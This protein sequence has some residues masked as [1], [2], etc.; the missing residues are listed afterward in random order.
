MN[1]SEFCRVD[2]SQN[3]IS[4]EGAKLLTEALRI[5]PNVCVVDVSNNNL[6]SVGCSYFFELLAETENIY[7]LNISSPKSYNR[8]KMNL[9]TSKN[10]AYSLARNSTL[11]F[12]DI[13]H[14]QIGP[15][16][17]LARK[18]IPPSTR[19]LSLPIRH[20]RKQLI[21]AVAL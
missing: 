12:L 20:S 10:I 14:S 1:H 15:A 6:S 8:N 16:G 17:Q 19:P 7:S 4:D 11:S 9:S 18:S 2:L 3:N 21:A 5:S 13:S